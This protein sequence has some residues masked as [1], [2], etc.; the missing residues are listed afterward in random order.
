MNFLPIPAATAEGKILGH[1]ISGPDGRRVLRKGKPLTAVDVARLLELGRETIYVAELELGDIDENEAARRIA[2]AVCGAN[3]PTHLRLSKAITGRCNIHATELGLLR[4][5][6]ARLLQVNLCE[7]VTLGTLTNHAVVTPDKMVATLKIVAYA[8]P[9]NI[10]REAETIGQFALTG[11]G[12]RSPLLRIDPLPARRVGLILSGSTAVGEKIISGFDRALR[13]RLESWGSQLERIEFVPL[14]D[15]TGEREL[16]ALLTQQVADGIEM[17]ILAGETAIMDRHDIAPRAVERAG[18][19]VTCFG[20]P[21]DPGNL[22]MLARLGDVPIVGAPGCARS[23]KQN[24]VDLVLP[25]LLA[26][27]YL[28]RMDIVRLGLG[29]MIDDVPERPLPREKAVRRKEV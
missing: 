1:N 22:L 10:V 7:A 11:E 23:P 29:G 4:V 13:P 6:E 18:G 24:I 26:G 3:F 5:D 17:I 9:E 27:D 20:A 14:E 25:R 2:T 28:T 21:V 19:R 16:A 8:V 12:W 15:E